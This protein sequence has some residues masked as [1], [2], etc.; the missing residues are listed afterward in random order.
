MRKE[1][2]VALALAW[3]TS[4]LAQEPSAYDP[5]VAARTAGEPERAITLL[6]PVLAA[7]PDNMDARLQLGLALLALNRLDEAEQAF[8]AVLAAAPDYADARVG[9]ARVAQRRGDA[10]GALAEL[11]RI[12]RAYP[13]AVVLRTQL[14]RPRWS[15][16][17]DGSYSALEDSPADWKGAAVQLRHQASPATAVTGRIEFARRFGMSDTFGEARL[18]QRLSEVSSIYVAL[19]AAPNADFL[20]Q[21]Q[22]ALGGAV[23]VRG[24][25]NATVLTL[26]ARFAEYATGDVQAISPGVEQYFAQGRVWATGRWINLFDEQGEHRSG[27]LARVDALA[28]DRL[29]LFA[30]YSNAPDTTEGVVIDT[31]AFF[32]GVSFDLDARTTLRASAAHE[33]RETGSDR[34]QFGLGLGLRF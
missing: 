29:R 18:D 13:G 20:P 14:E 21:W 34:T 27:Y 15:L 3:S 19:G 8:R 10:E 26:D 23:R 11:D 24:G 22:A 16:D 31:E 7:D 25:G 17:I 12:D 4:A 30:G 5:A 6:Q 2:L 32:G 9:L 28:T 1:L 33:D